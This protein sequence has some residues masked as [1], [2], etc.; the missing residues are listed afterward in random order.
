M[1]LMEEECRRQWTMMEWIGIM[2]KLQG[3]VH[4]Q[5]DGNDHEDED[6]DDWGDEEDAEGEETLRKRKNKWMRRRMTG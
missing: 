3:D 5:V 1:G 2:P 4:D 6:D